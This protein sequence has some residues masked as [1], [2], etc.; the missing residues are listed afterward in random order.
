MNPPLAAEGCVVGVEG[1]EPFVKEAGQPLRRR[2]CPLYRQHPEVPALGDLR[3]DHELDDI[4][5]H[6]LVDIG[7]GPVRLGLGYLLLETVEK[8]V[9]SGELEGQG[10]REVKRMVSPMW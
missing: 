5:R 2:G 10:A 4:R 9:P 8:T 6:L 1:H 3:A 7:H